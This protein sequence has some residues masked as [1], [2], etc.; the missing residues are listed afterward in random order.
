M[1]LKQNT[2]IIRQR[3]HGRNSRQEIGQSRTAKRQSYNGSNRQSH[4]NR[5]DRGS[6][7][8]ENIPQEKISYWLRKREIIV[9]LKCEGKIMIKYRSEDCYDTDKTGFE[10]ENSIYRY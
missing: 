8:Y 10:L 4:Y 5:N 9:I 6:R 2:A 7:Q 1:L 3:L